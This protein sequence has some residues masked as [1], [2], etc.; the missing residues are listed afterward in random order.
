MTPAVRLDHV[1][2]AVSDWRRAADFYRTVVGA[3]VIDRGAGRVCFRFGDHAAER[4]WA[5]FLS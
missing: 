1:I 2:I 3:E 5:R 4:S